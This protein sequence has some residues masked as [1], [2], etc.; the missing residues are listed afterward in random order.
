MVYISRR[1]LAKR[2]KRKIKRAAVVF[3]TVVMMCVVLLCAVRWP[4]AG[5]NRKNA[6]DISV[7]AFSGQPYTEVNGNIPFFKETDYNT[8]SFE[9]YSSLDLLGR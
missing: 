7:P 8:E 4:Y 9:Q 6:A 3:E 5:W 1:Q 2:R